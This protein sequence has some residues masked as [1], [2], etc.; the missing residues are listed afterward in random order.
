M[1][2]LELPVV[3]ISGEV[4]T[5]RLLALTASAF[6]VLAAEPTYLLIDTAVI[7]HLGSRQLGGLGLAVAV[8]SLLLVVGDFVEYGTTGRVARA[9]GA[10][11]LQ[12]AHAEGVQASWVGFGVGVLLLAVG[13][14][15]A[16]PLTRLLAGGSGYI[17]TEAA[18]WLRISLIGLP[19]VL[20]VL[21]GNGWMRG[22]STVK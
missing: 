16:V 9:F 13:E 12:E 17:A 2:R 18:G 14:L 4:G 10:G 22:V 7:G 6:V 3:S 1:S 11:R 5:R 20:L 8:V 19:G 15:T 21:A